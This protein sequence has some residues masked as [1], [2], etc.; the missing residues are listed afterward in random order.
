MDHRKNCY[1]KYTIHIVIALVL[2][3]FLLAI[4]LQLCWRCLCTKVF[5]RTGYG[6]VLDPEVKGG[7][8]YI[9]HFTKIGSIADTDIS[10]VHEA[11]ASVATDGFMNDDTVD[12]VLGKTVLNGP[13]AQTGPRSLL[14]P[15]LDRESS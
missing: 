5:N 11:K 15:Q 8:Q 2:A 12:L 10:R 9:H 14:L 4:L 13:F 1:F 6:D 3:G 7:S